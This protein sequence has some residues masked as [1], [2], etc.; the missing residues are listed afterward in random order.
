M[1]A[2]IYEQRPWLRHYSPWVPADLEIPRENLVGVLQKHVIKRGSNP[3]LYYFCRSISFS[4]L[5]QWSNDLC[6]ALQ[7][8]GLKRGERVA[9]YL[10]NIPQFVIAQ[11]AVWKAGAIV[12][13][14]GVPSC[15]ALAKIVDL[16]TGEKN[17]LPDELG[18][19][20]VKG[21]M[22]IPGYWNN[23][24]ETAHAIRNGWLYTGGRGQDGQ[25][26]L[27]LWS[28]SE[29]RFNHRFRV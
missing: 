29:K 24:S 8:M 26:R 16:E 9:F 13:P 22:V 27:V 14:I 3:A 6:A 12:V 5:D 1:K 21:P 19:I 15:D 28:R 7:A 18:E 11:Y 23:P 17:L 20:V 25:E 4:E 10:Q 2:S